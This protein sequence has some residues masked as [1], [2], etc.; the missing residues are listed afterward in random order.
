MRKIWDA[1]TTTTKGDRKSLPSP[2][3]INLLLLSYVLAIFLETF[4]LQKKNEEP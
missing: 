4:H 3:L 2:I 1:S